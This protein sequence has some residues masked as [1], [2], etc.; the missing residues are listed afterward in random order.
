MRPMLG[1]LR[2][3]GT[4]E[5]DADKVIFIYRPYYYGITE[6]IN[7]NSQRNI[8]ELIIAKNNNGR[9]GNVAVKTADNFPSFT[10]LGT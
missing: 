1:H 6:D 9:P 5:Q 3:C 10:E 4:I 7:G 8:I 2:E